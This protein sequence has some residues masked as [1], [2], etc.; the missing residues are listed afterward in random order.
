MF[1]LYKLNKY[2]NT[3]INLFNIKEDNHKGINNKKDAYYEEFEYIEEERDDI[4]GNIIVC[5]DINSTYEENQ[6]KSESSISVSLEMFPGSPG[7]VAVKFP[8]PSAFS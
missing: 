7:I 1:L 6:S 5:F 2:K 4:E 3:K 8:L